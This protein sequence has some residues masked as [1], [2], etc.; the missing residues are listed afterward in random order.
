MQDTREHTRSYYAASRKLKIE[1]PSLVGEHRCD[2]AVVGA[3]FTGVST[4][5]YLA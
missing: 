3:G 5:L 4:T 1:Y 2:I